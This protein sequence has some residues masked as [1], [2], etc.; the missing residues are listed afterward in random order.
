MA[1]PNPLFQEMDKVIGYGVK[2]D[3]LCRSIEFLKNVFFIDLT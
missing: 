1:I 2:F 3:E